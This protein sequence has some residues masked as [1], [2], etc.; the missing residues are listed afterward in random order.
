MS[1]S[2]YFS[3]TTDLIT[4]QRMIKICSSLQENGYDVT[5]IGRKSKGI[6]SERPYKQVRLNCFFQRGKW[7]YIEYNIR[8]VFFLFTH[9]K[10]NAYTAIDLDTIIPMYIASRVRSVCR[11][12]DAHEWF[13][14]MKEVI[15]RPGIKRIWK[16]VEQTFVPKFPHGYT[17]SQSI[18]DS[19]QKLYNVSY[20]LIMNATILKNAEPGTETKNYLIYQGAV[21]EGRCLEWLIPAMKEV[22]MPLCIYGDGNFMDQCKQLIIQHRLTDKVILKGKTSPE[23]LSQITKTAYAGINLVE[24]IGQNQIMSLANKFFDYFHAGIPQLTMNFPEYK[25]INKLF[26][27]AILIDKPE[28]KLI[29]TELNNLIQNKVLYQE[30]KDNCVPAAKFFNWQEEEKKLLAFYKKLFNEA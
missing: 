11:V 19:F 28:P 18:A 27:M 2:I 23:E 22:D 7:M 26:N 13:S 4:D 25:R 1:K 3:V 12:Y 9:K 29:A 5:L 16:W 6:L 30:L 24:P 8:L 17:V 14:E 15:T 20:A 10:P 21:N